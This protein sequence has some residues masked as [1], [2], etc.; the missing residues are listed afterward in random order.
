[1]TTILLPCSVQLDYNDNLLETIV[2]LLDFYLL[3][4]WRILS[5]G[6]GW[7]SHTVT[8]I[9]FLA[10]TF[11]CTLPIILYIAYQFCKNISIEGHKFT[12][13]HNYSVP[14]SLNKVYYYY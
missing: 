6:L 10:F 11:L 8:Y 5:C 7:S 14:T 13:Y 12:S 4:M 3:N 2:N 9:A 1:M